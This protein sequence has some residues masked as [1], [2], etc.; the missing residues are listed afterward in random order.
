MAKTENRYIRIEDWKG[1]AYFP[2][3]NSK[4]STAGSITDSDT[5]SKDATGTNTKTD[6]DKVSD[7]TANG[8]TAIVVTSGSERQILLSTYLANVPFG[9]VSIGMRLKSSIAEGTVDL[10]EINTYF[11]DASGDELVETKLDTVTLNG[12]AFEVANEYVNLGIVTNFKGVSTGS[13]FLKVEIIVLPDTGATI[14]F[15]QLAVAM[16]M[17]SASGG[18]DIHVEDT[19]VVFNT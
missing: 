7:S 12:N 3:S 19:T 6:G 16:E 4:G 14:Y 9:R 18:V 8:G 11:V 5:A 17:K 1:N 13:T 15:D 10:V 2:E